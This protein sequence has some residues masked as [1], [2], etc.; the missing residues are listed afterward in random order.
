MDTL[1]VT[2]RPIDRGCWGLLVD[3]MGTEMRARH[4]ALIL[5]QQ[6]SD[7]YQTQGNSKDQ[8][9]HKYQHYGHCRSFRNNATSIDVLLNFTCDPVTSVT[10]GLGD[11]VIRT[12]GPPPPPAWWRGWRLILHSG[13]SPPHKNGCRCSCRL[14]HPLLLSYLDQN[15]VKFHEHSF[16]SSGV[17]TTAR[18]TR[19]R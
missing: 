7:L 11:Y 5:S 19:R 8:Q 1:L 3:M 13:D 4:T 6:S 17:L 18:W 10:C 16:S 9:E 2:L 15:D 14:E 12:G